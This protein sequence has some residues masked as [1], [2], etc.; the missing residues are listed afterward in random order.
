LQG[1]SHQKDFDSALYAMTR[2]STVSIVN[3]Q[4][5]IQSARNY[6]FLRSKG[7]TIRKTIDCLIATYCI[8][9]NLS[10]LHNDKDFGGFESHLNLKVIHP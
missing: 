4:I 1:F 6:R 2:F 7:I 10:L 8:E 9:N 5:A 3:Q